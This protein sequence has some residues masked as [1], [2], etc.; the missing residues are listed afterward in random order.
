MKCVTCKQGELHPGTTTFMADRDGTIFV[1][2]GV[3]ALI[4][5]NCQ[6]SYFE[7]PV[8]DDLL[9]KA[10]QAAKAGIEVDIQKYAAA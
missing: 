9:R 8:M 2:K 10:D 4:C 6:S 3:P 7:G 1:A 5:N